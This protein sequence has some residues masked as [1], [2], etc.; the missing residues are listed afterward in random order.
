MRPT[1]FTFPLVSLASVGTTLLA[2][3]LSLF[4]ANPDAPFFAQDAYTLALQTGALADTVVGRVGAVDPQGDTVHYEIVGS[5]PFAIDASGEIQHTRVLDYNATQVHSFQVLASDG[6]NETQVDVTARFL[7]PAGVTLERWTGI[8]GSDLSDLTDSAHFQNDLADFTDTIAQL[9]VPD[10]GIG[11]FGHRLTAV[12]VPPQSGEYTIGL[13]SDDASECRFSINGAP[14]D[15]SAIATFNGWTSYQNW[16]AAVESVPLQL[17]AGHAYYIEILHKEGGGGDHVSLGWKLT[18]ESTYSLIPSAELYQDYLTLEETKPSFGAH[19]TEYL[20]AGATAI[21]ATVADLGAVDLQGDSL[22]YAIIGTVPFAIDSQGVLTVD[23]ALP[24]G[25]ADYSFDVTVSDGTHTTTSSL[26]IRTTAT[27]AAED[28][29]SSGSVA[30]VTSEELLEAT[31]AEILAAQDLLLAEKRALFNLNA[32]GTAKGDGSSLTDIDWNPTHDTGLL[33]ST[34]GLNTPVLYTNAVTDDD[35]EVQTRELVIIG[36]QPGRYMVMGS[37]PMRNWYRNSASVNADMHSFLKNSF[38]WLTGRSDLDSVGFDVVIAHDDQGYYFPDQ[39]AIRDWLDT[40]Y[41]T[42]NYNAAGT[43][44]DEDLATALAVSPDLLIISQEDGIDPDAIAQT[45]ESALQAGIPVLYVHH[46][47]NLEPLGEALFS[48]FNVRYDG[49]N[50]WRKLQLLDYDASAVDMQSLPASVGSIQT[51]LAHFRDEDYAFD[52]SLADGENISGVTGLQEGFLDGLS[53]VRDMMTHW[54]ERGVDLFQGSLFRFDK[55]IALLGDSYRREVSFPMDKDESSDADFLMAYFAD[56]AVYNYR[57]INPVQPDMGNF[58]RSDFSHITPITKTIDLESKRNF[59]SA[60][61]YA[62]PGQTVAVTRLDSS[63]VEVE[64]FVNTQRSGSTHQWADWGYSRPKYLKSPQIP[65]VWG[66]TITLTSPYG[67][68]LQVAFDTNDL[69]VQ[70]RFEN[71]GE[72]PYWRGSQDDLSFTQKLD[73]ADYDWAEIG[74]PAF[75]VHSSLEKMNVSVANWGTPQLL[76]T[77]TMRYLHNFPHILAGFQGPGIDVVPEIHDFAAANGWTIDT[78]DLVKHMNA[79]Q[80][81][82]GYGC[83]GN[84]YDAYWSFG[85]TDH[86]DLHELGHGLEKGRF[87]MPGWEGHSTTN[88]YSYYA[89]THYHLD[90][91]NDPDCQNL[92]FEYVFEQLQ[93][94]VLE[95]DPV[96]WLQTNLWEDSSWS[97]QFMMLLQIIMVAKNEGALQDGWNAYARLHMLDREFNRSDDDDTVWLSKRDNLGFSNFTRTE[98]RALDNVDWMVIA[99]SY[100][101]RLDYRNFFR[102]YG[103]VPSVEADAQ[104]A[105]FAYPAAPQVFC[106]STSDGYGRGQG[107]NSMTL[108]I[109]GTQVWPDETDTDADEQ[110][111]HFD[112]DDDNDLMPDSFETTHGFDPLSSDDASLNPDGDAYDNVSEFIAGTSPNDSDSFFKVDQLMQHA[113]GHRELQWTGIAGRLYTIWVTDDLANDFTPLEGPN[114]SSDG[115][116]SYTDTRDISESQ[117]YKIEFELP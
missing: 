110:W 108:P 12:L 63:A 24:S 6:V 102:M 39:V 55:F 14:E 100:I 8:S 51:M 7:K 31:L 103:Y 19:A 37:N 70:L 57:S 98:A 104:V 2:S 48:V 21:D 30:Y 101:T 3:S 54:D 16:S 86:G 92:P 116:E 115:L 46:N 25:G 112:A 41:P 28:A 95:A 34:F 20:I 49:D 53:E 33:K 50:Y 44:N 1:L 87:R 35:Y 77:A 113:N 105:S 36:E 79:D 72:H 4:A 91:G 60:G 59:R 61:V 117:F 13:T 29:F 89:K 99:V 47:G 84:P 32:D 10:A 81:T 9:N 66:E 23:Q 68:P 80:A 45:V 65:I 43:A 64:V 11:S 85:P 93:A 40:Y 83:S 62:L 42:A 22:T 88:P 82:C 15:L 75:E 69:P 5:V 90:T 107:F 78:L 109:D 38:A 26:F 106:L 94:S 114:E 67:G 74:T 18:T 56:H 97:H 71:V 76:A 96:A 58:S 17:E 52:W 73:A 27:T 111:N